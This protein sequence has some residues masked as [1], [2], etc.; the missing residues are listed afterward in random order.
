MAD[1]GNLYHQAESVNDFLDLLI[2]K[3]ARYHLT[4]DLV[5]VVLIYTELP[6]LQ[7]PQE[8][9]LWINYGP[10]NNSDEVLKKLAAHNVVLGN[11]HR[12]VY[13][14]HVNRRDLQECQ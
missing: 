2:V 13:L 10:W 3:I 12:I 14:P 9:E 8:D 6:Q 7:V 4:K 11:F 5:N 1:E